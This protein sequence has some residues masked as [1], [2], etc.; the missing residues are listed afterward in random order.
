MC[1]VEVCSEPIVVHELTTSNICLHHCR[2]AHRVIYAKIS[3]L[4]ASIECNISTI[5][6]SFYAFFQSFSS[7]VLTVSFPFAAWKCKLS[8]WLYASGFVQLQQFSRYVCN[9]VSII[10]IFSV[11]ARVPMI[12]TTT[13]TKTVKTRNCHFLASFP[14]SDEINKKCSPSLFIQHFNL[15][16]RA[17]ILT[18]RHFCV[19]PKLM[20]IDAWT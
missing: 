2:R 19:W 20:H 16:I 5:F 9:S 3:N 1:R 18:T 14:I 8:K 11:C 15:D 7:S 4:L 10:I 12:T 13:T 6:L 17:G